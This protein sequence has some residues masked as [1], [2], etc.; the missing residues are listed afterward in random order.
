[1][2]K[3]S[4]MKSN[5]FWTLT[6]LLILLATVLFSSWLPAAP[7]KPNRVKP[8][9]VT[10]RTPAPKVIQSENKP[11]ENRPKPV[12]KIGGA[13]YVLVRIGKPYIYEMRESAGKK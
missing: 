6:C 2:N 13:D 10:R 1:M 11:N 4:G 8:N 9:R 7:A 3:N 12:I 5:I